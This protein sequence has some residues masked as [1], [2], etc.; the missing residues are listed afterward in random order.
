MI[1]VIF[2]RP[3][4][5]YQ[6]GLL[7]GQYCAYNTGSTGLFI[8]YLYP[9]LS[10]PAPTSAWQLSKAMLCPGIASVATDTTATNLSKY[11]IYED[12]GGWD[13]IKNSALSF[14]NPAPAKSGGA[15]GYP[16]NAA[17]GDAYKPS[18]RMSEVA[19][20]TSLSTAWHL[21]DADL[22]GSYNTN[23]GTYGN[24]WAPNIL[25]DKMI[26][27]SVR[28][29]LYFDGHVGVKKPRTVYGQY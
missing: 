20:K 1:T 4:P 15:F 29:Y 17:T 13:E 6:S 23:S 5:E 16:T 12:Q 27:G 26:H 8:Y 18:H 3:N 11:V 28:N 24:S 21:V 10:C 22:L 14:V 7:D 25:N 9:Y 19:A 2:C